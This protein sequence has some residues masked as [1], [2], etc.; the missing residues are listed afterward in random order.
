M[1]I[2]C[3]LCNSR[4]L[5]MI[6]SR[7]EYVLS[8][9]ENC[10]FVFLSNDFSY[11]DHY[12]ES[13]FGNY[14]NPQSLINSAHSKKG[15]FSYLDNESV[16]L[17]IYRTIFNLLRRYR[18]INGAKYIDVGCAGGSGLKMAKEFGAI[19]YGIDVSAEAVA[20]TKK[21]GFMDVQQG[22]LKDLDFSSFDIATLHDVL[23]HMQNPHSDISSLNKC[24]K[25]G[26]LVFVKNN[27][28]SLD[29][30][31]NDQSYFE[32]Q[33]EPPYHCSYFSEKQMLNLFNSHGFE[34][35]YRK[36]LWVNRFFEAYSSL[37]RFIRPEMRRAFEEN[38]KHRLDPA[39]AATFSRGSRVGRYVSDLFPSGFIFEKTMEENQT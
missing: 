23:E 37:K 3:P 35:V 22:E 9:C 6:G 8:F 30:F 16:H 26:G 13:Y 28:F 32:R 33:F 5:G 29:L 4:K 18:E 20:L 11:K 34:L 14:H 38:K 24:L 1:K 27:I 10:F 21:R 39:R 31:K 36:P 19:P 12:N 17:S 2:S 25:M 7:G 15:D